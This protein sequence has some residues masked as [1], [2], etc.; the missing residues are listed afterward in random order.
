M[1]T[2]LTRPVPTPAQLRSLDEDGFVVLPDFMSP[3]LLAELRECVESLYAEEGAAAGH[4]FRQEPGCRR[5]ANLVDKAEV[6]RRIMC[7]PRLLQSVRAVLGDDFKLSSINARSVEPNT[8][9]AQPLHCDMG[10]LPDARGNSVCNTVWMLDDFTAQNGAPRILPGS[11]R[12]GQLPE[13]VLEN[14]HARLPDEVIGTGVAGSVLILNA[15]AWHAGLANTTTQPRRALHVFFVRRDLPQQQY[16]RALIR[17]EIQQQ[18]NARQRWL[19]ALDDPQ[20]DALC[21]K[22]SGRSGFL[23]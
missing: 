14:P 18:L 22:D 10:V 3:S 12:W 8:L 17:S 13:Q 16:Q 4:E 21:R 7:D 2:R 15:H 11:H 1:K 6:F 20:N 9:D 19:L 5:L 23:K